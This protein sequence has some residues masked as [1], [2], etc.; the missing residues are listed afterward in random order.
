MNRFK[1]HILV[2]DDDPVIRDLIEQMQEFQWF[3]S[4]VQENYALKI[5]H[6]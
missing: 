5:F 4:Q 3:M 6:H 2:V 1:A